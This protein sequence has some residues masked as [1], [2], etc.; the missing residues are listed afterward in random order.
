MANRC[1]SVGRARA[2]RSRPRNPDLSG[3]RIGRIEKRR[4]LAAGVSMLTL[5]N[6][7]NL[8]RRLVCDYQKLVRVSVTNRDLHLPF[9]VGTG[10][11]TL[12]LSEGQLFSKNQCIREM[13]NAE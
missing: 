11:V 12:L 9:N 2:A 7:V 10:P 8:P 3:I 13:S 6:L 1:S 4:P 5:C